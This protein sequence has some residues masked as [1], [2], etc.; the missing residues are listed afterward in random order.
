MIELGAVEGWCVQLG[1]N[2]RL[3][4][5]EHICMCNRVLNKLW[6][7]PLL[8]GEGHSNQHANCIFFNINNLD[9]EKNLRFP[10]SKAHFIF[11]HQIY[12]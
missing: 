3:C 1:E 11:F 7:L 8:P 12:S 6:W 9:N 10:W 4:I 2:A 5:Y